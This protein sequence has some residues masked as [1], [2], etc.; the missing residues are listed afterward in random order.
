MESSTK[1]IKMDIFNFPTI[2]ETRTPEEVAESYAEAVKLHPFYD[3]AHCVIDFYDSGTIKDGRGE[4]IGV[5][6]RKALPKYAT[7]MASALLISAA[8]RTSLRSMI[9]GGESPLSGIAGYFDYRG[10]PVEL[11]SRKTSFTYEHEEAWSAVFPVVDYVSEIYRHV[12]PERWKAQNNA[13]PDLV[14]I[15]GTPFSTLTINSRFR[16]ASHTDVG[17]FDAGYSCIAC[18][19]GKFKGL[20]LTFDD[21]RINVLMQPRDVMVFDSHHFHS[22]TEVEVSC[23][24]EDWKRLTCVFYYRTALGEPSSYAEY[25][26]RLEKSKQDPSFTPVVSNVM[27]KENGTNLNR[28][29]PVHPVPPSPFWLPMLAH[30]LQHCASAAQSVHEAMTADGSQLAEIIFGEPLST[31]DGIPLRG[32]DE[33]LKANGDTGAKPLSRLGG[34]SETDLMVS[35]AAEKRKYLDSEFLSHCISAQ[36]LDMWKQARARWLE[37]VGKEWKH[38]LTLNPERKDFLWKNRSEMNSAFFDLCE[39]GKQVMLGLLD[40]EA[41]LPKEEQAFWTMYAVHLSAA[42]AEELHMPHDAM[43]LRKLN[44]KLKDFN[45]G[46]TRYFKDMPP[47]EQ[48]RRM[49]RKQ[50]IEEARRHGMT[51]AH[52]KRA[53]WLTNDSFDYQTEDCVVDYA[54][55]KWVLPERHAKAVTKNVHTAWLPTREEVVRVLVVLPDLQIRVE[56]VDCKLEKP[57]TVEDSSEWVRLVS[58]PAVHRLLAA[59]QR[60]LQLPDDVMHGNIHIRFVFHSTLPTDMYDFV[61]LQHVLSRIPDDVLAS[62]YITRAAALCSGCLFVEETDVQCRQYYTLKYSIRRNYDAV[63]PHFFQQLHQASYGTKMA[64]VRTKGELEA[65]IPTVCCARYKLQGSPLNTTIHVVS[66]TAPH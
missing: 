65:L 61:V 42:C 58:S 1:R 6:L 19:D 9:F 44:V 50:R 23:S 24:E 52:E 4:I 51:G 17:D 20:A 46:G 21:F 41:A 57:D 11:K 55:H 14:R 12:A 56:G 45:F 29:S 36:L 47:E 59:A 40:K 60:N 32:D 53:N 16:T 27:M 28:P 2:K 31:S 26:R 63:A 22:N 48:Q 30:C 10:S 35:T 33:K 62:S 13:I 25:R 43:S 37:L 34:F 15:H 7:S 66:P 39:V 64:R 49:E 8:V 5:V 18:I 3:N 38:M 54:K